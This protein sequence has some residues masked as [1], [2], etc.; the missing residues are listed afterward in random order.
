MRRI[1]PIFSVLSSGSED[2]SVKIWDWQL[3]GLERAIKVPTNA[4]TDV[5]SGG[6]RR[7]TQL[8]SCS[9]D[10]TIKLYDPSEDYQNI[11]TLPGHDYSVSAVRFIPLG[12]GNL[13]VSASRDKTLR[14]WDVLADHCVKIL[15]GHVDWVRGV[16]PSLGGRFLLSAGD[17]RIGQLWDIAMANPEAKLELIRHEHVGH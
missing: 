6:P 4:V 1:Y 11:R 13:F 15:Q 17:D 10:L 14:I 2:C 12:A 16:F 9:N 7:A 5:D 8:A 3:G